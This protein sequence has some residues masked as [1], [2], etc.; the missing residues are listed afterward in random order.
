L[1]SWLD[2]TASD[3]PELV[4]D[5]ITAVDQNQQIQR[6]MANIILKGLH[7]AVK[8]ELL[9]RVLKRLVQN[10]YSSTCISDDIVIVDIQPTSTLT[11]ATAYDNSLWEVVDFDKSMYSQLASSFSIT[12]NH[13]HHLSHFLRFRIGI[14]QHYDVDHLSDAIKEHQV[15][16][17]KVADLLVKTFLSPKTM[18]WDQQ[19]NFHQI[20][21]LDV[22]VLRGEQGPNYSKAVFSLYHSPL[23]SYR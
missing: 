6:K 1:F 19:A 11:S 12:S 20:V 8:S 3:K 21:I 18:K 9:N 15:L 22:T 2:P 13:V 17:N 7:E 14:I 23:L 10:S 5:V 16:F 4:S